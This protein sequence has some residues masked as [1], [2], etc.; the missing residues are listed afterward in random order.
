MDDGHW[1]EEAPIRRYV[2]SLWREPLGGP[3]DGSELRGTI[4]VVPVAGTEEEAAGPPRRVH[5]QGLQAIP[6]ILARFLPV[7]R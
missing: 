5:F 6:D 3:E 7:D 4:V 2:L 1:D